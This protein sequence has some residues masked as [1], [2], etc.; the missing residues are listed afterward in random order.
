M[1]CEDLHTI[2][3]ERKSHVSIFR[4]RPLEA[5]ISAEIRHPE[6]FNEI[7]IQDSVFGVIDHTLGTGSV[8][9]PNLKS[10]NNQNVSVLL[11]CLRLFARLSGGLPARLR[12]VFAGFKPGT[13]SV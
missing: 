8:L 9:P 7:L 1:A 6:I 13:A 3:A 2:G 12:A 5:E 11:D 10:Q 4:K